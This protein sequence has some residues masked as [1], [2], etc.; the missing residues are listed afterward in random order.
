MQVQ[1]SNLGESNLVCMGVA[2]KSAFLRSLLPA[3]Q[4]ILMTSL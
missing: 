1:F 4:V 2:W 3:L